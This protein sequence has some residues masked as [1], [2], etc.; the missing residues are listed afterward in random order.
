MSQHALSLAAVS[1]P[2]VR[3][4]VTPEQLVA[5]QRLFALKSHPSREERVDLAIQMDMELKTVTNWFQNRR[6]TSRRKSRR[7]AIAQNVSN[8][9]ANPPPPARKLH[10]SISLDN[11]AALKERATPTTPSKFERS[12]FD[13]IWTH[14]LSSPHRPPSSPGADSARMAALP[15]Q[16]RMRGSLEWACARA[17]AHKN[18][19]QEEDVKDDTRADPSAETDNES[20]SEADEAITP[21]VSAD[22]GLALGH[23][24][25]GLRDGRDVDVDAKTLAGD[26]EAAMLLLGFTGRQ[27]P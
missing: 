10:P 3:S 25:P 27:W 2:Y 26:V 13:D 17:R 19:R 12:A 18:T 24:Q 7:V 21:D 9:V 6:Q 15:R 5:L 16:F 1:V 11:I 23:E 14:M 20:E 8:L 22:F 4:R